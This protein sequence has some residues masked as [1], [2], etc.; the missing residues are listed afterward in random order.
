MACFIVP[1]AEALIMTAVKK[2]VKTK[3]DS[4]ITQ[5]A[6]NADQNI[7]ESAAVSECEKIPFSR[8]LSWLTNLLWGGTGLLAYEH[9][10]HGEVTPY[11]PFLTAASNPQGTA[12][13]IREMSTAGVAMAAVIT[14]VWAGML[15]VSKAIEKRTS[16]DEACVKNMKTQEM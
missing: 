4:Q 6:G 12:A 8:K 16:D 1:A 15:A 11:F 13:V 5:T 7:S 14:I 10:W 3:E 2:G 9:I